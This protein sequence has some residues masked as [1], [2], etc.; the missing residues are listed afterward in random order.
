TPYAA[1]M[2]KGFNVPIIHVNADDVEACVAAMRLA[3]AY[4]DRWCRDV[5]IDVIG[6]RRF[7]HNETDEPAYTQPT[8]AAKIKS[9]PPVSEI[10]SEQ[11]TEAG[12]VSAEEVGKVSDERH[13][14]MSQALKKLRE[15]ME[16]GEYEDPTVTGATTSTGEL[17]DRTASPP[18]HTAVEAGKLRGLNQ[19][20]L[21]T[22]EGFNVH[23]KLRRPLS[24][25]TDALEGGGV[26]YGQAEALAFAS[27]LTEGVHIRLTG[28][29]TERGT[30]SHRHLVLHDEN[31]GLKYTPMQHLED[32]SAPFELYNSPL[33][34]TACLG[35]EY[36]YSA[37]SPS[38]LVL[39]EAQFGDFA[40]AAQ[41][42][43]DSFIVAGESKWGQTSRLTLLLPHGYEG[44]G[45]EHSSARIERFLALGAEGNIR[46]ANPTT[47]A[48]YFHLL[49]RQ[50][51]IKKP[52]PL[53]V[54]TPKGLLR[55]EKAAATIE[56]LTDGELQFILDDPTA[57][58]RKEKVERLVL[59]TG[60][61]Y[62]D[63]DSNERRAEAE[64]VAIARV[65]IL[66]PFAKEQLERVIASYPNL[67]EIAWVQEE[68]RNMGAWKVMSRRM[69]DILPEGVRLTYVGRQG[70]ASPG[71][72][73][74]GAHAREQERIVLT[75]LT[76]GA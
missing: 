16:A 49:R 42:I 34:E 37:A 15:K 59:C 32:A 67:K 26:D 13:G 27:L 8:M 73:Y 62:Y 64:K 5:V 4:R 44:S 41:V 48:Q 70:R 68:P 71:E 54:F 23:R 33:S 53:I 76:P 43:I 63:M 14:E 61:V 35:F 3:M 20:L 45:P 22:P 2:A 28:Q 75:A 74:S 10:Y 65:E 52:R 40:N 50:A 24:K 12:T 60:K 21:N 58:E 36:G 6:Y 9:H 56:D 69:P 25:R 47:A 7:G 39:W 46:I 29:D 19:A 17:L 38:A 57:A 51:L 55:L 18:V 72:G 1:D 31:T 66:Y 30:F 11:L